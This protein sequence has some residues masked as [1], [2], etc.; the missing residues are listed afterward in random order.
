VAFAH[1]RARLPWCSRRYA[2]WVRVFW[3]LNSRIDLADRMFYFFNPDLGNLL[4]VIYAVMLFAAV[5]CRDNGHRPYYF[6]ASRDQKCLR[7]DGMGHRAFP[8]PAVICVVDAQ[9]TAADYG[10]LT[11][12]RPCVAASDF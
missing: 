10:G 9:R 3:T 1:Y 5:E 4:V 12:G 7:Y 8:K 2:L 11:R 6:A